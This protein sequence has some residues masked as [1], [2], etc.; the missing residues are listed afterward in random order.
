MGHVAVDAARRKQTHEVQRGALFLCILHRGGQRGIL[1][2]I[3][4]LNGFCDLDELLVD[5]SARADIGVADLGIAHLPVRQT[6]IEPGGADDRV[7]VFREVPVK[8]RGVCG[9]DGIAV[10]AR[11]DA[12]AVHNQQC[13]WCFAHSIISP[14]RVIH[15][16]F[17]IL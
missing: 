11:I 10:I 12:E 6:D 7:R 14:F 2:E 3:A 16:D 8:I 13:N 15:F 17:G 5:D 1:K 4:V 9:F